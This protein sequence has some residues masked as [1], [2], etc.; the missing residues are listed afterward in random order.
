[1][2]APNNIAEDL[3]N[4]ATYNYILSGSKVVNNP[5]STNDMHPLWITG[6]FRA[7]TSIVTRIIQHMGIDLGPE[8]DLLK[9]K[10]FRAKLNPDGFFENYLLMDMSLH[11][12][13]KLNSWGDAPPDPEDVEQFD[14]SGTHYKDF[15]YDS[16]V[17]IHD[18]RISN[19]NKGRVL[20]NYYPGNLPN[21]FHDRFNHRFAVKNPHFCLLFPILDK[22]FQNGE[23]LVVFRNP[24][25]LIRSAQQITPKANYELYLA[26]YSRILDHPKALF[27]DYDALIRNPQQ[28]LEA[29]ARKLH[30]PCNLN[31]LIP[32]I[33]TSPEKKPEPRNIPE[34][35]LTLYQNMLNKSINKPS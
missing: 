2:K 22:L 32:L 23:Y 15:V 11:V 21:Y 20:K 1:M 7:G 8:D 34:H 19:K 27:F 24:D 30:I 9:P 17:L 14:L 29:L 4:K 26:Y 3:V 25:D 18:D 28:S 12:F 33:R 35:V 5:V 31:D 10:G 16:V 6:M 13:K